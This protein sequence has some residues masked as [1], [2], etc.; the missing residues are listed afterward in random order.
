MWSKSMPDRG[1]I[2]RVV[3]ALRLVASFSLLG[4][5]ITGVL[6]GWWDTPSYDPRAIGAGVGAVAG[7][8]VKL[9]H[10]L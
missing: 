10:I 7:I 8:A 2:V 3:K 1:T 6:V 5:V 4:A 9:L